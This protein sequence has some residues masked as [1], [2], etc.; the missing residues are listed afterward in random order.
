MRGTIRQLIDD[1]DPQRDALLAP[2]REPLTYAELG[3]QVDRLA[4]QLASAGIGAS[5]RVAIVLPNG[6]ELAVTFLAVASCATAAPLNP[7]YGEE[8]L[9]FYLGDLSVKAIVTGPEAPDAVLRDAPANARCLT[10]EGEAGELR[11]A[12]DGREIPVGSAAP[13]AP[14]DVALALHTSGTISRPKLVPLTHRNLTASAHSIRSSLELGPLDRCM[15]VMPL[16][17]IHGLVGAVLSTLAAGASVV[18][19]PGFDAFRFF[20]WLDETRP[21]WF[22]AVPTMH[23][24]LLRRAAAHAEV[25]ERSRLRLLRSSS[26]SMPPAVLEE[27]ERVFGVPLIEAYGMT[28]ASHQMTVNPLPPRARKPGSVGPPT[29]VE[30]RILDAEGRSVPQGDRAEVAIRGAG[31]TAGYVANPS[32]NAA[33]FTDGWFRTG[34]EGYLDEDGYLFLTGRLKEL[35]NRGGEKISPREV[36]EVL[37]RHPQVEQAVAFA[38]PHSILGEE[39]AAAVI[40]AGDAPTEGELRDFARVYLAP[41]KVPRRVVFVDEIPQGPTGKLQ[42]IGLAQRLGLT[43]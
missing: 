35:I 8:E 27:A 15:N 36:D 14:D 30:V 32:A 20:P 19:T 42:R 18:C 31:V 26:A 43:D 24:L 37:L 17:H 12:D 11:L 28:E 40:V 41:F 38:L 3:A 25:I 29:S 23:Q 6:P 2:G 5:D 39:V 10:L 4:G 16:F 33:A 22:T 9:R 1:A 34:D 21:T 13:A 7:A